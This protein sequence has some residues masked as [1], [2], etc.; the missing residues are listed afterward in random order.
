MQAEAGQALAFWRP[1]VTTSKK[2]PACHRIRSQ[3]LFSEV[4]F[5]EIKAGMMDD[6]GPPDQMD[7]MSCHQPKSEAP[8]PSASG[9][10]TRI[11][12]GQVRSGLLLGRS[13]GP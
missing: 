3:K 4:R 9:L 11:R 2:I 7:E 13:L 6:S 8:I 10:A 5:T 12:S 1:S